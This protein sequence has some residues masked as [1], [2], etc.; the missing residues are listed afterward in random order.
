MFG[1]FLD[2]HITEP[3]GTLK[4][5]LFEVPRNGTFQSTKADV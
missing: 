1:I 5:A 2:P 3:T 4:I